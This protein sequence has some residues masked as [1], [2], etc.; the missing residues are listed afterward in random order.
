MR[1]WN[2]PAAEFLIQPRHEPCKFC[3]FK[4]R[5]ASERVLQSVSGFFGIAAWTSGVGKVEMSAGLPD[6]TFVLGERADD[7]A[8]P[9]A[10]LLYASDG[11]T[12]PTRQVRD[13]G[14][15]AEAPPIGPELRTQCAWP[16]TRHQP[17]GWSWTAW[18]HV[19][20]QGTR[21]GLGELKILPAAREIP[22]LTCGD[23]TNII[24]RI[25]RDWRQTAAVGGVRLH[26]RSRRDQ[27]KAQL[28]G[29]MD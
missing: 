19:S 23:V 11:G 16:A 5:Q 4:S 8:R 13:L 29:G 28:R 2:G 9:E 6:E 15:W 3:A 17:F 22:D 24:P 1:L 12:G 7:G 25:S 20:G 21:C 26:T 27:A 14:G 18:C 10:L